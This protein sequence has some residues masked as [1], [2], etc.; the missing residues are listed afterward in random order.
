MG[1]R[2]KLV[3]C[4]LLSLAW[5][6]LA[7]SQETYFVTLVKG[8]IKRGDAVKIKV[9]D[10]LV[11]R[12]KVIFSRKD[13]R[14]ILLHPQKG[15][16]IIEPLNVQPEPSGEYLVYLRDN[17]LPN[18]QTVKLSTRGDADLD[19]YFTINP[20]ISKNL[21]FIGDSRISLD[22]A[23]YRISDPSND[24]F[25]LQYS[26]ASGKPSSKR[27]MVQQDSLQLNR[28][29]FLFNGTPPSDSE[30]VRIGFLQNYST[31]KKVTKISSFFP[32][33]MS[34]E[35]CKVILRTIKEI[36]GN[37]EEKVIDEAMTQLYYQYGKPDK[38]TLVSI[39][40]SL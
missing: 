1:C 7:F 30:E 34:I 39:Y 19:E 5:T 32:V 27:L 16:F 29:D 12:E 18:Q 6:S 20:S 28:S 15:R 24:F 40:R 21:L 11:T 4:L 23:K 38:H 35:D 37:D 36:L 31:D 17:F 33:F 25:F 13:G 9:G 10:K 3:C 2:I 8:E 26:P 14:L 22:N